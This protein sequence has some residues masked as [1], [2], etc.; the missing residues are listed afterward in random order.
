LPTK[1]AVNISSTFLV[2]HSPFSVVFKSI[3]NTSAVALIGEGGFCNYFAVFSFFS[4]LCK[5]IPVNVSS[6]IVSG[7]KLYR[8]LKLKG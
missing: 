1:K 6:G 5:A 8:Y 4:V 3:K 7:I 2:F